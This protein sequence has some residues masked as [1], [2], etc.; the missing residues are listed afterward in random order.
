MSPLYEKSSLSNNLHQANISGQ[1]PQSIV[2][3]WAIIYYSIYS[4]QCVLSFKLWGGW[5]LNPWTSYVKGQ[6][7]NRKGALWY[8]RD[9]IALITRAQR[10]ILVL[11]ENTSICADIYPSSGE[12][13][14]IKSRETMIYR[15]PW[16]WT[17]T[18]WGAWMLMVCKRYTL[19]Q[20][21]GLFTT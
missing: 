18:I 3:P 9:P 2:G 5:N 1:A 7:L 14:K 13:A 10:Q 17:T 6:F 15:N 8:C 4:R 11:A 20:P 21:L 12:F 19:L 16:Q